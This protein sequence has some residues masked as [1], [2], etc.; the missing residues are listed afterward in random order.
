M[1]GLRDIDISGLLLDDTRACCTMWKGRHEIRHR[2]GVGK[3][4]EKYMRV[5]ALD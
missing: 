3:N 5:I 1:L 2:F 4:V